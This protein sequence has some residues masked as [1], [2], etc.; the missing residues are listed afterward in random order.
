MHRAPLLALVL[1][2]C[3]PGRSPGGE[4][5][6][7]TDSP[8]TGD[9][10]TSAIGSETGE[11]GSSSGGASSSGS[12][13]AGSSSEGSTSGDTTSEPGSTTDASTGGTLT[14]SSTGAVDLCGD[15]Q[16]DPGEAC[17]DGQATKLCDDDCTPVACGDAHLNEAAGEECDD[18]N[19]DETDGCRSSC[20]LPKCGDGMLDD[21]EACDD[22][23]AVDGDGCDNDCT[24]SWWENEGVAYDVQIADLKGW[25]PCWEG[26]SGDSLIDGVKA[27]AGQQLLA[28]CAPPLEQV[29][30]MAAHGPKAEV[31]AP[32]SILA[33][34]TVNG[35]QWAYGASNFGFSAP[36]VDMNT[37]G[38]LLLWGMVQYDL[39]GLSKCEDFNA[40]KSSFRRLLFTR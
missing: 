23:N 11:P 3:A 16:V 7:T 10:S 25:M 5:G 36:G 1:V 15:G 26:K 35:A 6:E 24:K 17:D 14:G 4:S 13:S 2:A 8:T 31:T 19:V 29:L 27:C 34:H 30:T 38:P 9:G 39:N 28:A 40:P 18:G 32:A 22:G 21:G 20:L 12:A 37:E 33:P